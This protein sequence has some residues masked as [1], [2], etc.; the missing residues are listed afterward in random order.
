MSHPFDDNHLTFGDFKNIIDLSLSGQL[1]REDNVTE[2]LDGQ[3]LMVSW[4][5]GK[6]R[7]A[8]N[9]GNLQNFGA[10]SLDINGMASKFA[11]RGN[12]KD[13]F[14]FAMKDLEKAIGSLSDKQKEK[15]FGNGNKWMNLEV[16]YPKAPRIIDYDV[17]ELFFH[18]SI[19]IDES[20]RTI[21]Q[22]KGSARML[23]GMIRQVN[24][25]VQRK[26]K[27]SNPIALSLPK[28]QNFGKNIFYLS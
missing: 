9:K 1:N 24:Q 15:V 22:V 27:I 28:V 10:S 26:F 11:G 4:I 12:I 3:N 16:I 21:S 20:G 17:S 14:V 13:A 18:G 7:A 23:E 25:H 2:K 19:E 8:R 6:L 5:G